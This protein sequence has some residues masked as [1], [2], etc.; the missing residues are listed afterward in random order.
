MSESK[1][2]CTFFLN[3]DMFGV[4]VLKVQEVLRLQEMTRIPLASPV[5]RGLLNLRGH[6][7]T[8]LDMRQ[9]LGME[10]ASG[11]DSLVTNIVIQTEQGLVSLLVDRIGDVVEVTDE[12]YEEAPPTVQGRLAGLVPGVYKLKDRLLM[13]FDIEKIVAFEAAA[14]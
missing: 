3:N 7:V 6:I 11:D 12:A 9:R 4:E 5:V 2:Y 8:T 14:A 13:I 1:Q 10:P